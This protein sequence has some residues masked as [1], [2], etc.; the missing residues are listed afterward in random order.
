MASALT[1][2]QRNAPTMRN[3]LTRPT[4][5][6]NISLGWHILSQVIAMSLAIYMGL[7]RRDHVADRQ[8]VNLFLIIMPS[9]FL[10]GLVWFLPRLLSQKNPESQAVIRSGYIRFGE[11]F[12][13]SCITV[14]GV[15]CTL[16]TR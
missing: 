6:L 2:P 14:L 7:V 16:T 9:A 1:Q 10:L 8:M 15:F 4:A 5:D 13:V 11:R 3:L 12:W